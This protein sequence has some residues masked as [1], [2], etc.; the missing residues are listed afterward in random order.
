MNYFLKIDQADLDKEMQ[1]IK[2]KSI[3]L[4]QLI[5]KLQYIKAVFDEAYTN[6]N[7]LARKA[8]MEVYENEE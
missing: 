4:E 1:T 5:F 2:R 3:E 7:N 6:L 8:E